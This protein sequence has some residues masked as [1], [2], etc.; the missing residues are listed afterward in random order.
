MYSG[1]CNTHSWDRG[2][3]GRTVNDAGIINGRGWFTYTL[4]VWIR[5]S[6]SMIGKRRSD[7]GKRDGCHEMIVAVAWGRERGRPPLF[8]EV[9]AV[10]S[11]AKDTTKDRLEDDG[12]EDTR[13]EDKFMD[14]FEGAVVPA[15]EN[16]AAEMEEGMMVLLIVHQMWRMIG[17]SVDQATCSWRWMNRDSEQQ[18]V[19]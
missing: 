19:L 7:T 6:G 10:A 13:F 15:E 14:E 18:C 11:P 16:V 2:R 4:S 12:F 8:N 9:D 3:L 5:D 1:W 17:W